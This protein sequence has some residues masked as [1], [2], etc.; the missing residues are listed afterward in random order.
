MQL[1]QKKITYLAHQ[2]SKDGVQ[3]SSSNSEVFTEC[4]PSQTYME[5]CAFL[6]LVDHYRRFIKGL[7]CIA[8]PLSKYLTGEGAS[9]KSGWMLFREDV[10][11][12][13]KALK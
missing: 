11:K 9:R 5:V 12:A 3:P 6:G 4:T 2:V 7:A 1:F 8:Q 13:F 10:L